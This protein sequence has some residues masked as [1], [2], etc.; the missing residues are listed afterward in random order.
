[1][2]IP[3]RLLKLVP[4]WESRLF[5]SAGRLEMAGML[6]GPQPRTQPA[7]SSD[8]QHKNDANNGSHKEAQTEAHRLFAGAAF[9]VAPQDFD[10]EIEPDDCW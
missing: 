7:R 6:P 1:M 8:S 2:R 5:V 3:V 4:R 9:E 10:L